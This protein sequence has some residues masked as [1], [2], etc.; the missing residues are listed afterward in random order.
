[1]RNPKPLFITAAIQLTA[2]KG[3]V[4]RKK[5]LLKCYRSALDPG[6][7][8]RPQYCL[9]V[10]DYPHNSFIHPLK[11]NTLLEIRDQLQP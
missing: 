7:S 5:A 2:L 6:V 3:V 10:Y 4:G 9:A 8:L 11:Q 1:M